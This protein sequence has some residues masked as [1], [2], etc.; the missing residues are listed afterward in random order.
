MKIVK[1][2]ITTDD[3]KE[4]LGIEYENSSIL[5]TKSEVGSDN[6]LTF[7]CVVTD[8]EINLE[9]KRERLVYIENK[10]L[11]DNVKKLSAMTSITFDECLEY[12]TKAIESLK[13]KGE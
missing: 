6:T 5:F 8:E 2:Y 13:T 4:K 10:L 9:S 1:L 12:I 7:E 11:Y 3:I